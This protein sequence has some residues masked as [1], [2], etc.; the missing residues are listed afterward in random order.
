MF[1]T[2]SR[3]ESQVTTPFDDNIMEFKVF[4]SSISLIKKSWIR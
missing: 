4:Y 2:K 3:I 1:L